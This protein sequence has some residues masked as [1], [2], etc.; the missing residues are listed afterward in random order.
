VCF[1]EGLGVDRPDGAAVAAPL[2]AVGVPP[3]TAVDEAEVLSVV[4]GLAFARS[5]LSVSA[6]VAHAFIRERLKDG[7]VV[8]VVGGRLA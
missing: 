5:G 2:L 4:D 8:V 3:T 1:A 7:F 6:G